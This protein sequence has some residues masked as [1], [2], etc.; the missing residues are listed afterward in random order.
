[1]LNNNCSFSRKEGITLLNKNIKRIIISL[2]AITLLL[3]GCNG[4]A[5]DEDT[6]RTNE[7]TGGSGGMESGTGNG[8]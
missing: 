1:M 5:Q 7:T 4:T 3:T 8:G 6:T 2:A